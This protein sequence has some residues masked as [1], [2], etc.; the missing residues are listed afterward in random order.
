[1]TKRNRQRVTTIARIQRGPFP[2][3]AEV[4]RGRV[5]TVVDHKAARTNRRH[6]C[7]LSPTSRLMSLT[8]WHYRGL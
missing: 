4:A 2:K 3:N 1:V 5:R 7:H 6:Y 8:G